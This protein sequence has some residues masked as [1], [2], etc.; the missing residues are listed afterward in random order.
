M[1]FLSQNGQPAQQH[2]LL[3]TA[4]S[5]PG[6]VV[7]IE[8]LD[9][10]H[11]SAADR[12]GLGHFGELFGSDPQSPSPTGLSNA[13]TAVFDWLDGPGEGHGLGSGASSNGI[14]GNESNNFLRA[15]N[16]FEQSAG[17][18]GNGQQAAAIYGTAGLNPYY[19]VGK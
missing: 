12:D 11:H 10:H 16:Y 18:A 17:T 7:V 5:P 8:E 6:T 15:P 13:S 14:V 4:H 1:L 3:Q 9:S 2:F 19:Q